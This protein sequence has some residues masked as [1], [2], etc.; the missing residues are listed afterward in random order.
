VG[1]A[2]TEKAASLPSLLTALSASPAALE[3]DGYLTVCRRPWNPDE[4][5][6]RLR[7]PR[8]QAPP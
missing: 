3:L 8:F 7:A 1:W 5:V 6:D 4:T 2:G